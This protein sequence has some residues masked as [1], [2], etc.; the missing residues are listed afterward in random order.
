MTSWLLKTTCN[1]MES[2]V[3][4]GN[5]HLGEEA[6]MELLGYWRWIKKTLCET[7]QCVVLECWL[8][9]WSIHQTEFVKCQKELDFICDIM[10]RNMFWGTFFHKYPIVLFLSRTSTY[11]LEGINLKPWHF[12]PTIFQQFPHTYYSHVCRTFFSLYNLNIVETLRNQDS[13]V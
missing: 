13:R 3:Q 9:I 12:I 10:K 11:R 1:S 2:G 6:V 8:N 5:L 4:E 7:L